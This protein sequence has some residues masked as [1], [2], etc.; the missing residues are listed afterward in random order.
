MSQVRVND[1]G[2]AA[3]PFAR[4]LGRTRTE[5]KALDSAAAAD[6]TSGGEYHAR[7]RE[8]TLKGE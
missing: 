1:G 6:I 5:K 2:A 8:V 7:E 4:A 3:R